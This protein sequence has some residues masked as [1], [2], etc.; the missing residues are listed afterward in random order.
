MHRVVH[1][2]IPPFFG[3]GIEVAPVD[4]MMG[5]GATLFS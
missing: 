2:V 4:I 1:Q 5:L 3:G